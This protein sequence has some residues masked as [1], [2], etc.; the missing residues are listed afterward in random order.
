MKRTFFLLLVLTISP[1][2]VESQNGGLNESLQ[3]TPVSP[4]FQRFTDEHGLSQNSIRHILQDGKGFLWFGTMNGLNRFD[5]YQFVVYRHD[6]QDEKSLTDNLIHSIYETSSGQIWVGTSN[7]LNRYEQ[8]TDNFKTYKF[9]ANNPKN[10][11][12]GIVQSIFEDR[13]GTLWVGTSK[14]GLSK[15]DKAA[16]NFTNY[17]TEPNNN[18]SLSSNNV[19]GIVED[20]NGGFWIATSGGLNKF[21]RETGRFS[22][23][24]ADK[25]DPNALS[26]NWIQAMFIDRAGVVWL[27]TFGGGLNKFD[28]NTERFTH[29]LADANNPNSLDDN[30]VF[31]I[32]ETPSGAFWVGTKTGLNRYDQ[33]TDGFT[34]YRHEPTNPRS[35]S[36]GEIWSIFEDRTEQLWV[37]SSFAGANKFNQKTKRFHQFKHDANNPNSI[38][39][40]DILAIYEDRNK[41]LWIGTRGG[42][43]NR[44][45][46]ASRRFEVVKSDISKPVINIYEDREGK[47]W[48]GTEG[49]GLF[50][51]DRESGRFTKFQDSNQPDSLITGFINKIYQDRDGFLWL[52][53]KTQGLYKL[54]K[55]AQKL[56]LFQ[57]DP[58][59]PNSLSGNSIRAILEDNSGALW[60]GTDMGLNKFDKLTETFSHL[61]HAPGNRKTPSSDKI[62]ALYEDKDATLWIGTS[63][64]GLNRLDRN[65][66]IFT[67]FTEREGLPN[68]QVYDILEDEQANLWLSTDKGLARFNPLTNGF[69]N[70][71]TGDGLTHNEFNH[72]AA[73]KSA[74][75]EMFFGGFNGFV[76]FNPK[77]FADSNFQPPIVLSGIRI[78]E[79]PVQTGQNITELKELNLSWQDYVVSFEFAALDFT[80]PKKLQ[81]QWKLEGFDN[82]WIHGGIRRT[83]TYTHLPGGEYV[84]KVKATNADGVWSEESL[85]LKIIVTPPFYRTIWFFALVALAVGGLVG[86]LYRSRINQLR[87]IS[88]A[89]TKFTQQ[90]IASQEAERKRIAKELHDG[91]GQNLAIISNR[92]AMGKNKNN[93]PEIVAREFEEI[94]NNAL[95][96][97]DEV[98]EI[99][100]NL[101]PHYLERLGLTKAIK[102][103]LSKVSDVLEIVSE[104]DPVDDLFP[105]EAEINVYRIVQESVNN[106]I[107]HSDA[108]EAE[109]KVKRAGDE[110]VITIEDDG[111]GF[112]PS[113]VK[114]K[115]GGLG[116]VGLKERANM[117]GGAIFIDSSVGRG[118]KIQVNLP[119]KL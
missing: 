33:E 21:N 12:D 60:F 15:F 31:S 69:R 103:M 1:T 98:Q 6:F 85:N 105:K 51:F 54:D 110:V 65:T 96:A 115:G 78:F 17:Q 109:I 18:E 101:H 19:H 112:D 62:S 22:R 53:T 29:Y 88:E 79:Q 92:A 38:S 89:Q 95:E 47:L 99:T 52:G 3:N 72:K 16:E 113:N 23:Y 55:R 118:T 73:F 59:N 32:Y 87:A 25:N 58:K 5:G 111:R 116:L 119:I 37:A 24:Q 49:D 20:K 117:I 114:A 90:L 56:T 106:I 108:S 64:G 74:D 94:S 75:G 86:L 81:Y 35:L 100:S 14:G 77:D 61:K 97:L 82:D 4:A 13:A 102:S 28:P 40:G 7:G 36:V 43:L 8:A 10:L 11:G 83:A 34:V 41:T 39:D 30:R 71:D 104:I 91:L 46:S 50:S 27:G 9:D 63:F 93:E 26:N 66:G 42:G 48:F 57:H 84:L 2:S 68:N 67:Y 45:D 44:Y 70:F 80:D 107:K 76:K